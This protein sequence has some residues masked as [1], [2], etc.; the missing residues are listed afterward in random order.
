MA[1]GAD[2]SNYQPQAT[3]PA[4][5]AAYDFG[6]VQVFNEHGGDNPIWRAQY[7][8]AKA[9]HM[10]YGVGVYG[11]AIAGA[12]NAALGRRLYDSAPDA[13]LGW[14][15]D[16]EIGGRA[17]MPS[18]GDVLAF[19]SGIPSPRNGYYS[20]GSDYIGLTCAWWYA[21]PSG[22]PAPRTPLITQI[23]TPNNVD[24]NVADDTLLAA[25]TGG[26]TPNPKRR[27]PMD[28]PWLVH[29]VDDPSI[30]WTLFTPGQ[31]PYV[32]VSDQQAFSLAANNQCVNIGDRNK[33]QFDR[34]RE[35]VDQN[36]GQ[37]Q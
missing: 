4:F 13:E 36:T 26:S 5:W 2:V 31:K 34:I 12:D 14:W 30:N 32:Q 8:A 21:N 35:G 22:N 17:Q 7:D 6:I 18:V 24:T 25:F 15:D 23:G 33:L 20:N 11:W 3:D 16:H 28:L 1:H 19:L 27:V 37:A 9:A 29:V 10:R